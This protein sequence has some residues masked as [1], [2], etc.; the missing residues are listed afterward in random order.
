MSRVTLGIP[1]RSEDGHTH[2]GTAHPLF[3]DVEQRTTLK[4]HPDAGNSAVHSV[5]GE[6]GGMI[7]RYREFILF[8]ND[9]HLIEYLV[10]YKRVR[11]H[12]DCESNPE[13]EVRTVGKRTKNFGR[14]FRFCAAG[15]VDGPRGGCGFKVMDPACKCGP[16]CSAEVGVSGQNAKLPGRE[17]YTCGKS[18]RCDFFQWKESSFAKSDA[19]TSTS[20]R[21]RR[22]ADVESPAKRLRVRGAAAAGVVAVGSGYVSNQL[23]DLVGDDFFNDDDD[24]D[25]PSGAAAAGGAAVTRG[26]VIASSRSKDSAAEQL[27]GLVDGDFFNDDD[28]TDRSG[29]AAAAGRPLVAGVAAVASGTVAQDSVAEQLVGLVDSAFFDDDDDAMST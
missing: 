11:R 22:D 3:A 10:A 16:T 18:P 29:A 8:N 13:L 25:S 27:I 7:H 19:N 28:D 14:T 2:L 6:L 26:A 9:Q 21:Q 5:I 12:C 23:F 24:D 4:P 1:A 17:F 15:S 20:Q